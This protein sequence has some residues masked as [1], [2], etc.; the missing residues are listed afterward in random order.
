MKHFLLATFAML[1]TLVGTAVGETQRPNI[2]FILAD[3]MGYGDVHALNPKSR[4]PVIHHSSGGMFAI[5]DGKWKLV[6]GNGSGGRQQPR[7]KAFKK[8]YQLFDISTDPS[9][10]TNVIDEYPDV[11]QKL[12]LACHRIIDNESSR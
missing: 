2:V 9:E 4:A 7:G 8:P 3:D 12:E 1:A 5:R 10:K 6:L 11:A